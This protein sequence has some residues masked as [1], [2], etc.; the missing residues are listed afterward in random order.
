MNMSSLWE[1]VTIVKKVIAEGTSR[2]L[3]GRLMKAGQPVPGSELV[4]MTLKLYDVATNGDINGHSGTNILNTNGGA[5]DEAGNWEMALKPADNPV[6][7]DANPTEAHIALIEWSR[8]ADDAGK[9]V[10][11]LTVGNISKVP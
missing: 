3:S 8:G 1:D 10:V 11:V 9:H 5:I 2:T 4:S 7:T 6:V